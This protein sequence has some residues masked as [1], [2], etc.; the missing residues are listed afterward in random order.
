MKNDL[1]EEVVDLKADRE[2]DVNS[3]RGTKSR[4]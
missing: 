4:A 3:K 2:E 1:Q